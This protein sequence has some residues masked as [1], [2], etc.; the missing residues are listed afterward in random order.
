MAQK[1]AAKSTGRNTSSDKPD[2]KQPDASKQVTLDAVLGPAD[3]ADVMPRLDGAKPTS[4][5]EDMRDS[6]PDW[7]DEVIAIALL[8]FGILSFLALFN[9]TQAVVAVAWADILR[10]LFGTGSLLVA[11]V[12]FGMG[13]FILLPKFGIHIKL[14]PT[15]ILGL[16]ITFL[17]IMAIL[18][19]LVNEPEL[20]ALAR[21]G[22]GGGLIGW[23]LTAVPHWFLG[24]IPTLVIYTA[25]IL[26]G[27]GMII[28][29]Q[30][31]QVVS[32]FKLSSERL[33]SFAERITPSDNDIAEIMGRAETYGI[34]ESILTSRETPL[35]RIRPNPESLPPSL[36]ELRRRAGKRTKK[37]RAED[38]EDLDNHPL[39]VKNREELIGEFNQ[40][41]QVSKKKMEDGHL[42][43]T[44]PDGREKRYFEVK[45]MEEAKKIGKRD[46]VLPAL[47]ILA[48]IPMDPPDENEINRNVVLIENTLLEF[49][50]DIDVI[51]VQVGPTV[52]RYAVQPYQRKRDG[53]IERTRLSKIASF[54]NDLSLALSAK[55]LRLETPVPGTTYMGIE[56]PNSSPSIVHLR[57]V[58][59]SKD[60]YEY[61]QRK[62]TPLT[63]P[64][65]RDVAGRPVPVDLAKMPHLLIAGTTGSGKSVCIA[66]LATALIMNNRPDKVK[67]VMLDPKMVELSRFNGIPH[68]VG[69]V[70]TEMERIIGVLKWCT[71]E[72]DRRYKLLEE[73][74]VRNID[75]YNEKFG[76]RRRGADYMPYIVILIDEV[77]DM[78]MSQ[79]EETE[80]AITRLAQMA[81]AVGMHLVVATQRPSVDVITGLIKANFPGRIAFS[82]ASGVDSRVILDGTGAETLLGDGDMLFQAPDAAG[83]KRIQGCFISDD[84]VRQITQHWKDWH[85]EQLD[86]GKVEPERAPWER[87]LTRREFL[88]E[89]DPMLEEVIELVVETQEASASMIQ[90]RM[91]LGYPRAA[92]LVDMLA[93]LGV[94]GE[95]VGGGRARR[96]L[97]PKGED[98]FKRIIEKRLEEKTH[99]SEES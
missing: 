28:G 67:M 2:T 39:F 29:V 82:V 76:S 14:Q 78:M 40:I 85:Q 94:V 4:F 99:R 53:T 33:K 10:Q 83:P 66:A 42:I 72:M 90:R 38:Y 34:P 62:G 1:Q 43:V 31:E 25:L 57:S 92:R 84:E 55:R 22:G 71:R 51:D 60:Y 6:I 91:G 46:K 16:E 59:E 7:L 5:L 21:N 79:P 15:R 36:R 87:G 88:A 96:V 48:D 98:P 69:P 27:I 17:C 3:S 65:G 32:W 70:E 56:V 80:T 8:I 20:R 50:I 23:G 12:L 24:R 68:L 93:E 86:S 95:A 61:S 81:R 11:T 19:L 74:A 41:G 58:Y 64:L 97:I 54:H 52:T 49:D 13:V 9:S 47:D 30:R 44:R 26:V 45:K 75:N 73:H 35:L 18:H 89:T 37:R 77:G 63:V